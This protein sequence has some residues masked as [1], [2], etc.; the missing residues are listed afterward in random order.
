[1]MS[2]SVMRGTLVSTCRPSASRQAAISFSTEFLAPPA[3]T[4]PDRGPLGVTTKRST[5]TSMARCRRGT[6]IGRTV[7]SPP[8]SRTR[9]PILG[10]IAPAASHY[11]LGP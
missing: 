8:D 5:A 3:R 9:M 10:P 7:A 4:V 6:L 11:R 2:T 1:M